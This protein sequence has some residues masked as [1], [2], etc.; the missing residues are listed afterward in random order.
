MEP[1][2]AI[3]YFFIQVN[4]DYPIPRLILSQMFKALI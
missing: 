4:P 2:L 1:C 3:R